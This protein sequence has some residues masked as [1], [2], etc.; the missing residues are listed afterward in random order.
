MTA[1]TNHSSVR[2]PEQESVKGSLA[3]RYTPFEPESGVKASPPDGTSYTADNPAAES[4]GCGSCGATLSG[5]NV[6][7]AAEA[8]FRAFHPNVTHTVNRRGE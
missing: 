7:P 5:D 8:M 2:L 3:S 6:N 4:F 1:P